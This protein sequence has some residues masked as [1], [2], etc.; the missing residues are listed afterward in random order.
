MSV[1]EMKIL[2]S[3]TKLI[4]NLEP[5]KQA[6][7]KHKSDLLAA[8]KRNA[9]LKNFTRAEIAGVEHRLRVM[10]TE[11]SVVIEPHEA[12]EQSFR[13]EIAIV[14]VRLKTVKEING[15]PR[16]SDLPILAQLTSCG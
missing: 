2:E 16:N 13:A 8:S 12:S 10:E 4:S 7:E 3:G 9:D 1:F 6:V 11:P 14:E 15:H 5:V